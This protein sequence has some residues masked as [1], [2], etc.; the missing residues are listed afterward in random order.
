MEEKKTKVMKLIEAINK[1]LKARE[2]WAYQK[3]DSFGEGR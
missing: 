2:N 3:S 1:S